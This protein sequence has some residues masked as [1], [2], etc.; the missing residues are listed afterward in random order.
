MVNGR[1][2]VLPW[3]REA[4]SWTAGLLHHLGRTARRVALAPILIVAAA[5][6]LQLAVGVDSKGD[7]ASAFA[8]YPMLRAT[9]APKVEEVISTAN[10]P[11]A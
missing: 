3:L 10:P 8:D 5:R 1:I 2:H 4:S 9:A 6:D 11:E 7:D